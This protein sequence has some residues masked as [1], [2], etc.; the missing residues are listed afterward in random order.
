MV[1]VSRFAF[2]VAMLLSVAAH[3]QDGFS[4]AWPDVSP[5]FTK[6]C[7]MCHSEIAG[8][9]KGLRLDTYASAI[10]GSE[11]GAVLIPG[12]VSESEL[13]RR[14]RGESQPRMPFLGRALPEAEIELIE[15]WIAAGLPEGSELR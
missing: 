7:V 11:R 3:A 2:F 4:P 10:N 15:T 14:L 8:A 9:S 12:N 13:I 5:I 1:R 6:R